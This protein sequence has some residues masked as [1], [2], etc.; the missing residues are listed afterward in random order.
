MKLSEQFPSET[1]RGIDIKGMH[2]GLRRTIADYEIREYENGPKPV[3]HFREDDRKLVLNK[4]NGV[5]IADFYG[6]EMDQW[7][8]R[9]IIMMH[10]RVE[11]R[12]KKTDAIRVSIPNDEPSVVEQRQTR[13]DAAQQ[14]QQARPQPPRQPAPPP[15][16]QAQ[17]V[18]APEEKQRGRTYSQTTQAPKPQYDERNPPPVELDDEI[19]F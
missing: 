14:P 12:G 7:I 19:P 13:P 2:S 6:D 15:V 10:V 8:G 18:A 3:L 1:Y 11:F 4:T 16:Q 9:D 17:R 5:E